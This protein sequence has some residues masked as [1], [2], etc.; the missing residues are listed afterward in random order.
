M[1]P[2]TLHQK[3]SVTQVKIA[4]LRPATYNPRRWDAAAKEHLKESIRKFGAVD[5]LIVNGA[6]KRKNIV[7][8]G[9]FRLAVMKE[10]GYTEAPVVYLSIPSI[11]R[12]KELNIRLN[13]NAGEWDLEKL[14]AFDVEFLLKIGF[15]D[16][17]L[18]QIWD[19][20]IG[21]EDDNFNLD[22]AVQEIKK[23]Q[24]K[25][26]DMYDI[27]GH[28][29]I[30]GD[31]TD[32]SVTK[33]LMG[34]TRIDMLYSDPPYNI[35]VDYSAGISGKM[36]YGGKTND[37]KSD[38]EYR[39]FLM[40]AL[41]N[42]LS[43]CK[44][45]CHVFTY[46]DQQYIGMMQA[47]YPELGIDFKRV[48]LW[49][50]NNFNMTPQVAFNKCYEPVIYG[51]RGKPYLSPRAQNFTEILNKEIANGNRAI[52]D[53]LDLLD[54]WLCKRLPTN[55]YEHP[56]AKNPTLHE[57]PLRRCTKPGDAVLDLFGGGGSTLIAVHQ[58]KRKCFIVEWEPLF[59]DVTL[60]RFEAA[61]G[62]KPTL[63]KP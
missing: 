63:L 6:P 5:P 54:I 37:N 51:T 47:L 12:E 20:A 31:S 9:H 23:P 58:M 2:S 36:N 49:I 40:K 38:E 29:I 14:K 35:S 10:L 43:V 1:T 32:P 61:F 19:D 62:I 60:R 30:C 22:E 59:I 56:T 42:G 24:S 41:V 26:G 18:S 16:A 44:D 8:G 33:R 13:R 48:A 25:P 28:R 52:D 57:R 7:I 3:L 46:V 11:K 39:E 15:D 45:N 21:T 55:E 4:A 53:V 34:K 27:A 17:D 50:K